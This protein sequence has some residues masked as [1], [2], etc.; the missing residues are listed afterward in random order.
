MIPLSNISATRDGPFVAKCLL[1][2]GGVEVEVV[3]LVPATG[4]QQRDPDRDQDSRQ[5]RH[6]HSQRYG[7]QAAGAGQ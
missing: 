7:H 1:C 2:E 4:T 3:T 6:S 5:P